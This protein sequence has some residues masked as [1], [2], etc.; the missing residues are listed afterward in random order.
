M[1]FLKKN[2]LCVFK[3]TLKEINKQIFYLFI[4][5]FNYNI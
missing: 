5:Y 3:Y 2:V 1:W 4:Y